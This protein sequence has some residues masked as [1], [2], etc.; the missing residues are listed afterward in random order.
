M[1]LE[2][3]YDALAST[4]KRAD[5]QEKLKIIFETQF[6]VATLLEAINQAH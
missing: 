1:L 4:S 5:T 2:L 3:D 6:S